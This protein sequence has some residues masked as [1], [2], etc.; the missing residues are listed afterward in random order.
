MHGHLTFA[1]PTSFRPFMNRI[2]SVFLLAANLW[3]KIMI[4][5][6]L[7]SRINCDTWVIR[8]ALSSMNQEVFF[9]IPSILSSL[10]VRSLSFAG[11]AIS[12]KYQSVFLKKNPF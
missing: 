11:V 2:I 5:F 10:Q 3:D 1:I 9:S 8:K 7:K 6:I 4:F 12:G